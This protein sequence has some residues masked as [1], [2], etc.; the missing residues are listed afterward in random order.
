MKCSSIKK[1][2]EVAI[3]QYGDLEVKLEWNTGIW[4]TSNCLFIHTNYEID[5]KELVISVIDPKKRIEMEQKA[6]KECEKARRCKLRL[7]RKEREE[8]FREEF[9][10]AEASLKAKGITMTPVKPPKAKKAKKAKAK[11][12]SPKP[13][14]PKAKAK[15]PKAK[16]N[17]RKG[18]KANG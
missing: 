8:L 13:K 3:K 17:A 11:A 15:A 4:D 6:Q 1:A 10:R 12:T 14:A 2:L 16:P 7:T 18:K 9:A 5:T